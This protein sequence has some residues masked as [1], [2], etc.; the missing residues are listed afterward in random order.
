MALEPKTAD[1][2]QRNPDA[3]RDREARVRAARES[4]TKAVDERKKEQD[5]ANAESYRRMHASKPTPTQRENDLAKVGALN[6]DE[7]EDDGSGPDRG[8]R[9]VR[10]NVEAGAPAP[11]T[12]RDANAKKD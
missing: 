10:R 4:A 1:V 8:V 3:A 12:T 5:E 11:Y 2:A 7:K 9:Q 6:I